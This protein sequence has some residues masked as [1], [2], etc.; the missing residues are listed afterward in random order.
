MSQ[1]DFGYGQQNPN[2]SA[3]D[4]NGTSFMIQQAIGRMDT[5]K[6]VKVVAVHSNGEVDAPGTVDVLPLVNQIDGNSNAVK[7]ATIYGIPWT[8]GQG[9]TNAVICDPQVGDI[10][11]LVVSDRDIS[12]VKSAKKQSNPG[13]FRKFNVADGV[14]IG[15]IL[16]A[17]PEQYIVF[18][19]TGLRIVDKN[20]NMIEMKA[21]GIVVTDSN[22]NVINL[23]T[24]GVSITPK[25]GQPVTVNGNL[26]VTGN[27]NLQG[28]IKNESGALYAGN[29]VTAGNI[30]SGSGTGDQV[31]LQTH[32]HGG[33][34]TGGGQT[35][36]PVPGT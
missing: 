24:G 34:S 26:V 36:V 30:I 35:A 4:F 32:K 9:G 6:V 17:T 16:N 29:I 21:G 12:N 1:S 14:Y 28:S 20:G 10:G 8:R 5:M 3:S 18:T 11:F 22:Q 27:M 25:S 13:S 7:H 15:G 33:V 31:G 23:A 19:E 2:S